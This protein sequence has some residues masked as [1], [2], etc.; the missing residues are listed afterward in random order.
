MCFKRKK[1]TWGRITPDIIM[2]WEL[3]DRAAPSMKKTQA[4]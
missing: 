1:Y 4:L 3:T 2:G